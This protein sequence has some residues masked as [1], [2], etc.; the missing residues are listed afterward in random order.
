MKSKRV[1]LVT[2][3]RL[4]YDDML[5]VIRALVKDLEMWPGEKNPEFFDSMKAARAILKQIEG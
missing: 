4:D 5:A 1:E 2:I 3:A